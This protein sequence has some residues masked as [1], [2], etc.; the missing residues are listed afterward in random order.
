MKKSTKTAIM[1]GVIIAL[2]IAC[3]VMTVKL[4][5]RKIVPTSEPESSTSEI[6][7]SI[8]SGFYQESSED[9]DKSDIIVRAKIN[10][11]NVNVR[12]QP[13]TDAERLGSAYYGNTFDYV[14][15]SHDGWTRITYDGQVAYVYSDFVELV[16]MVLTVDGDFTEYLGADAPSMEEMIVWEDAEG[17]GGTEEIVATN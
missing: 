5:T 3:G 10:D 2:F 9:V 8:S 6:Q 13:N 1:Y 14:S 17:G 16:P 4:A 15:Q 7:S 12:V 11:D